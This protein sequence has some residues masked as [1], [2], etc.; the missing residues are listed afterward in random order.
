MDNFH[1]PGATY[2]RIFWKVLPDM[3]QHYMERRYITDG[4]GD[5]D[6]AG[7]SEAERTEKP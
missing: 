5:C 7:Y 6:I 4:N 3:R 1:K 2:S